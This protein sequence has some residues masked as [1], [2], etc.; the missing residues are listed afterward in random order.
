M[1][2]TAS[3]TNSSHP[4]CVRPSSTESALYLVNMLCPLQNYGGIT[5]KW[6]L[7]WSFVIISASGLRPKVEETSKYL[8]YSFRSGPCF[9]YRLKRVPDHDCYHD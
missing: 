2:L 4:P 7:F 5:S 3:Q 1:Y 6:S 8:P 9:V